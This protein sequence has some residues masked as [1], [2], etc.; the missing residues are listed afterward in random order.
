M[1]FDC[2]TNADGKKSHLLSLCFVIHFFNL[3]N[4]TAHT[5]SYT[6]NATIMLT[7]QFIAMSKCIGRLFGYALHKWQQCSVWF[8]CV[9][10]HD[11]LCRI[12][13]M[14]LSV[15]FYALFLSCSHSDA[16]DVKYMHFIPMRILSNFV[17]NVR[18]S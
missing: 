9:F 10:G 2:A 13:L 18:R 4:Y 17:K 16:N 14:S 6:N 5:I 8:G 12:V 3:L 1:R 11:L 7:V 15:L